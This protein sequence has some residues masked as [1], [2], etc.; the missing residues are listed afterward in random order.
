[1]FLKNND[2]FELRDLTERIFY[3]REF[4]LEHMPSDD[5]EYE[6]IINEYNQLCIERDMIEKEYG[7][8]DK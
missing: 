2:Y 4:L 5:D 8:M 6:K 7:L 3:I 1:M